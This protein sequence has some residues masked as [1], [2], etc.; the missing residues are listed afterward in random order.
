MPQHKKPCPGGHEIYN[1]GKPIFGH[2]YYILDMSD[3]CLGIERIFLYIDF[4]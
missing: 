1:F 2:L 4:F 3:K